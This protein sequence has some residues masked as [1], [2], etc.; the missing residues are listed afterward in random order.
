MAGDHKP[1][2]LRRAEGRLDQATG[3]PHEEPRFAEPGAGSGDVGAREDEQR[4]EAGATWP[5][6]GV[7]TSTGAQGRGLLVGSLIGGAIGLVL[8]LPLGFIPL[9]GLSLTGRLI[10]CGIIGALA[11]GTA[12][13]MYLGGRLPEL[14]GETV[15]ADGRPSVGST[16]RDPRTDEHG[17]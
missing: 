15:D 8:L 9:V 12:G 16:P 13:A 10:L 6:L 2:A 4:R 3:S 14:E 1:D 17:R 7:P 5:Q 11:G